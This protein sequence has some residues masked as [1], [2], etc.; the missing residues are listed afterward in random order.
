M[1]Y[2]QEACVHAPQNVD[3]GTEIPEPGFRMMLIDACKIAERWT[4]LGQFDFAVDSAP[5]L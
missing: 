2:Q 3:L 5:R 4:G 1:H